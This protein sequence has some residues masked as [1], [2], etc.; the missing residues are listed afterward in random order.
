MNYAELIIIFPHEPNLSAQQGYRECENATADNFQKVVLLLSDLIREYKDFLAQLSLESLY[1][2]IKCST[3]SVAG[4]FITSPSNISCQVYN[5]R[6][7]DSI[8][9]TV[10][11]APKE[12]AVDRI[13][14]SHMSIRVSLSMDSR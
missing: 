11:S 3:G 4:I 7:I 9:G 12:I 14:W 8:Y 10:I 5:T 13:H 6:M 2:G 1:M